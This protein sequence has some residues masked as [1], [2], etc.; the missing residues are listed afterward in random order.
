MIEA[1]FL[2]IIVVVI[3]QTIIGMMWYGPILFGNIWMK[4]HGFNNQT[5][6]VKEKIEKSMKWYYM[7]QLILSFIMAYILY[8]NVKAWPVAN[9]LGSAFSLWLGFAIP[10]LGSEIIWGSHSDSDKWKKFLISG[11]YYLVTMLLAGYIFF[12]W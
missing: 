7:F 8:F 1:N 2:A 11:G 12:V 10:V 6:E 3:L 9:G 5:K 4:I